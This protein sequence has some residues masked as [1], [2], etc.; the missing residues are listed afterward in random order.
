MDGFVSDD[1]LPISDVWQ[2]YCPLGS[3]YGHGQGVNDGITVVVDGSTPVTVTVKK[4]WDDPFY[5]HIVLKEN[6][7]QT[8]AMVEELM[9]NVQYELALDHE[10]AGSNVGLV[11]KYE[12]D[13]G[14]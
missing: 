10:R 6:R 7:R 11:P 2:S 9:D 12:T 5:Y 4:I 14:Q 3:R 8:E 1:K 13:E